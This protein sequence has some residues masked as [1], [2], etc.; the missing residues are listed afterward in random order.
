MLLLE[1]VTRWL[2]KQAETVYTSSIAL[3]REDAN[4]ANQV[5]L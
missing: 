4:E 2:N 1:F 3:L 5:D